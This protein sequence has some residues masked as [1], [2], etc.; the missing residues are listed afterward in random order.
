MPKGNFDL[1]ESKQT[2]GCRSKQIRVILILVICLM[3]TVCATVVLA[4]ILGVQLSKTTRT[5]N[6]SDFCQEETCIATAARI[7]GSL[8]PKVDPCE[9]FYQFSCG[10]WIEDQIIPDDSG[11]INIFKNLDDD[12]LKS[13]RVLL[14]KVP[15]LDDKSPTS[16]ARTFYKSCMNESLVNEVSTSTIIQF[17]EEMGDWPI[18]S[19][20]EFND[21]NWSLEKSLGKARQYNTFI[22]WPIPSGVIFGL[23]VLHDYKV[24]GKYV[25]YLDEPELVLGG[26][27]VYLQ[28]PTSSV[29]KAYHEFGKAV[30]VKLGADRRQAAKDFKDLI[31]FETQLA[32]I[33]VPSH[34][35]RDAE[36]NYN[37]MTVQ[38]LS[39]RYP[40][41]DWLLYL[42]TVF[43]F[44]ESAIAMNGTEP[45]I[46]WMP[47]Y[48]EKLFKLLNGTSTRTVKNYIVWRLIQPT[49]TGLDEEMLQ[50][51]LKFAKVVTGQKQLQPRWKICT[52]MTR[53]YLGQAISRL[54]IDNHFGSKQREDVLDIIKYLQREFMKMVEENGWMDDSTKSQALLKLNAMTKMIGYPD[55]IQND[56]YLTEY[57]SEFDV[58]PDDL[59]G[60]II[61]S[62]KAL[63]IK[64]LRL[65][66]KKA[67]KKWPTIPAEVNAYYHNGQNAIVFPAGI[68]KEPFYNWN[69]PRSMNF[70]GIGMAI[71]HEITHGY[72]LS[73]HAYDERGLIRNWWSRFSLDKFKNKSKCLSDQY[74]DYM[75]KDIQMKVN[76][77]KTLDENIADVGGLRQSFYA[78]KLWVHEN[79]EETMKL[80]GLHFTHEQL[81]FINNAQIWCAKY[82]NEYARTLLMVDTH[83]PSKYRVLG[84]LRNNHEFAEAFHCKPGSYMRL[85]DPCSLW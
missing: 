28:G 3:A 62:Q 77:I 11:F 51:N 56:T 50:I 66:I 68:I 15:S 32:N 57:Y 33:T 39:E 6:S 78:Y 46:V 23:T 26:R 71:G 84:E 59:Y 8:D 60:N 54:F 38:I 22:N 13:L 65:L 67:E 19:L 81:F 1:S 44:D 42:Q 80:P 4:V 47:A 16:I 55:D 70:G 10:K 34:E 53:S 2:T 63:A 69:Y 72:D 17:I 45:V 85:D 41:F 73:G 40:Q 35:R 82:S 58:R 48:F 43:T 21:T 9:D 75:V 24:A 31:E 29:M 52:K 12:L 49:L 25:L 20:K 36:K 27:D 18:L 14:E 64:Q 30:A 5:E 37:K 61:R 76:G 74:S 79:G 83:S 7:L